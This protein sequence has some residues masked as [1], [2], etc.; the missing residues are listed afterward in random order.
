MVF[1]PTAVSAPSG[2]GDDYDFEKLFASSF[3]TDD[4]FDAVFHR[5]EHLFSRACSIVEA[6]EGWGVGD[7]QAAA[8]W[9]VTAMVD[10]EG[11]DVD[12]D[13]DSTNANSQQRKRKIRQTN[14]YRYQFGDILTAPFYTNF[15][16]P[17]VRGRTHR[18][19]TDDRFGQFRAWFRLPLH[20]ISDLA[21]QFINEGYVH[22]THRIRSNTILQAKAELIVL[23]CLNVLAHGTPFRC[24]IH[25]APNEQ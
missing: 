9:T 23:A 1:Y 14:R 12:S 4:Q 20:M 11:S 5:S 8:S 22:A 15:L 7:W 19:G 18:L 10:W 25:P 6:A 21:D 24:H 13:T 17:D 16:A 3:G 2:D